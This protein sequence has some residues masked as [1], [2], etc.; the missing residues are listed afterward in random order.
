[1]LTVK[2]LLLFSVFKLVFSADKSLIFTAVTCDMS[3]EHVMPNCTCNITS[4]EG[5]SAMNLD[6]NL[7]TP[8]N[9][10]KVIF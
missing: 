9:I 3:S 6:Y 2:A 10:V 8:L 4:I 7:K 5:K 1:M